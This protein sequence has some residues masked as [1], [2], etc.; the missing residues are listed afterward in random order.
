[1]AFPIGV[2][3]VYVSLL[4]WAVLFVR[5][6]QTRSFR[7]VILFGLALAVYLNGRYLIEGAPAG[8][9]FFIGI[10]DVV[11]NLFIGADMP[12][13]MAPCVGAADSCT[14]WGDRY[15]WHSSWG[16]AFHDRFASG[17]DVRSW[18]LYAHLTFNTLAFVL[19]HAQMARPGASFAGIS[20]KLLG[21]IT[22][23]FMTFGVI[24]AVWLASQHGSVTEY[25]GGWAQWG[26][27]SMGAFVFGTALMG[28]LSIRGGDPARHRIWMWRFAGSMWGSFWLFRAML[29][30]LDP[31]LR[32]YESAAILTCIWGSAPL[33][34]LIAEAIRRYVD[35]RTRAGAPRHAPAE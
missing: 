11:N 24:C 21:R 14:V 29:L 20:H 15:A 19:L 7:L 23:G 28:V 27:Y 3:A 33:G 30:V 34:I 35:T 5:A 25:G 9:A 10:Y 6:L 4:I 2:V 22:F 31:T 26:F 12:G 8:I 1:M 13:G 16:V 17:S 18:L 32:G